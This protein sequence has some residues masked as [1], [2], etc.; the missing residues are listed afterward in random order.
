MEVVTST[1]ATQGAGSRFAVEFQDRAFTIAGGVHI[2][3]RGSVSFVNQFDFRGVDRFYWVTASQENLRRGW[4]G[5]Q[6]ERKWFTVVHGEVTVAVVR[7]D[8]FD[9]PRRDLPLWYFKLSS[10]SPQI[11][12]V[13]PGHATASV[14]KSADAV[15]TVFS[16]GKISDTPSDCLR[17]AIDFWPL[18]S[19]NL[20][21][22]ALKGSAT[23][24]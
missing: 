6:R 5:H 2:D 21:S 15:L 24:T 17:W 14:H 16:S 12:H 23:P 8:S 19:E 10:S 11:L 13:P 1:G 3:G 7:L 9:S 20:E 4:I 18:E 22:K